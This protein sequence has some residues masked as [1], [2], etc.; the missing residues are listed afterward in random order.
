MTVPENIVGKQFGQYKVLEEVDPYIAPNGTHM[1]KFMCRCSCGSELIVSWNTLKYTD[2]PKC[3]KCAG[4]AHRLNRVGQRF[5]KLT[6]LSMDEDYV[7][8]QGVHLA[9]CKCRCDCGNE[10]VVLMSQLVK[11]GTKSCGCIQNTRG[12][13]KDFPEFIANYDY[14]KNKDIDLDRLTVANNKKVWW[15]CPDCGRSWKAAVSSQTNLKIKHGCPYCSG[16]L[17]TKGKN[18]LASQYPD[19]LKEWDYEK[20]TIKPD[21]ISCKS[22]QKVFWKCAE[23]GHAW[24]Q[25]VANRTYN[26]SGCPKCNLENVNSFCEQ[27][28]YFY[29]KQLFSDAINGDC[30]LGVELDIYIPSQKVAIEYDGEVWH[31]SKKKNEID[32]RKNKICKEYGI[33]LIRIR[34]PKLNSI[35]DCTVFVREDSTSIKSLNKVI[36]KVLQYLCPNNVVDVDVDRD[37]PKILEQYA[38]KKYKNSLAYC[39]P[40]IAKEWHPT[41]NGYLTPDKVNKGSN[42]K[43]WWLGRCGHEWQ[44]VVAD[45][46]RK[47]F[48]DKNK[49][50]RKPQG[51]PYCSSKR[52]LVGFNDL[53]SQ[54]PEIAKEWHPTK[55]GELHPTDIISGSNKK[56]WWKCKN[57]HEWQ[58]TPN[59]RTGLK[60]NCPIC[61]DRR[62]SP[63]VVCVETGCVFYDAKE[64]ADWAEIKYPRTIYKCCRGEVKS[65]GGYHWKYAEM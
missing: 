12:L 42:Y 15:K 37:T 35:D 9:R 10:C 39:N 64:A 65:A 23:C 44:M 59:K 61:W 25:T 43:V 50:L 22:K 3:R 1:R 8:P 19:Y 6:V 29:V 36:T 21:E 47:P 63:S 18:D 4:K 45:R 30:H 17:V 26:G 58:S 20:N 62:R 2:N 53:K 52:V 54:F 7:S 13:L 38:T 32:N 60:R 51:C 49:K 48:Y 31:K 27:A 33:G 34:E 56:V 55:N 24:K 40:E 41:L 16:R 57:G 11:G 5:G 28:V 46:T 14:E